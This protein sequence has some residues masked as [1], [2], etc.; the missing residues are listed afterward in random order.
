MLQ[1]VSRGAGL[2][3]KLIDNQRQI[4]LLLLEQSRLAAEFV[5]TDFW[6]EEGFTTPYDWIRINCHLTSNVVGDR[7]AVLG[8]GSPSSR[9][10]CRRCGRVRLATRI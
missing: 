3:Q 8:S 5:E 4:D 9:R 2:G 1:L 6:E 7:V 10:A